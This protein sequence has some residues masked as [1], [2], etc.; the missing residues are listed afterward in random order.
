[1]FIFYLIAKQ[2]RVS[3]IFIFA[4]L[5]PYNLVHTREWSWMLIIFL[6]V[7]WKAKYCYLFC[8]VSLGFSLF[9]FVLLL[10]LTLHIV[11]EAWCPRRCLI[12]YNKSR[13]RRWVNVPFLLMKEERKTQKGSESA[14]GSSQFGKGEFRKLFFKCSLVLGRLELQLMLLILWHFFPF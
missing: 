1:M 10:L 6:C 9:C 14:E 11:K 5:S 2:E 3:F 7:L 12:I 4:F 13:S 8:L